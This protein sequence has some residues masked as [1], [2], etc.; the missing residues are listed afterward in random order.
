MT[1]Y[2]NGKRVCA[3]G[4]TFIEDKIIL[5]ERHRQENEKMLHYYT[6]PGGGVEENETYEE[7]SIRE[8]EEETQIIT[9]MIKY[10]GREEFESGIVYWYLLDYLSGTPTLGGEELERNNLLNHYKVIL[11]K[12]NEIDNLNILGEGKDF[13]EKAY[14]EYKKVKGDL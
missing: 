6:I 4:I 5:I 1:K 9:K 13:I 14:L 11:V 10:L 7:A 3:R 12:I 2:E 8:T